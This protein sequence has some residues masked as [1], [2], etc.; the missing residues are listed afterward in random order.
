M[1]LSTMNFVIY[2]IFTKKII[3]MNPTTCVVHVCVISSLERTI[4]NTVGN[5]ICCI[6][7]GIFLS[8]CE[9]DVLK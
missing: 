2:W 6:V 7:D 8:V 4:S 3:S 9:K 1:G 5:K